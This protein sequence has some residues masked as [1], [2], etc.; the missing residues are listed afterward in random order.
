M[1][2]RIDSIYCP[3]VIGFFLFFVSFL[4]YF[5]VSFSSMQYL[6][7]AIVHINHQ[8]Y[9][10]RGDGP[11]VSADFTHCKAPNTRVNLQAAVWHEVCLLKL[12]LS[13]VLSCLSS[14]WCSPRPGSSLSRSNRWHMNMASLPASRAP[15]STAEPPKDLRLE[16]WREVRVASSIAVCGVLCL[17]L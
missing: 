12:Y 17:N 8:P 14:V 3:F 5:C 1:D 4:S 13:Y 9:L 15:A 16:T 2:I 10:E 6:L 7:P 11:I